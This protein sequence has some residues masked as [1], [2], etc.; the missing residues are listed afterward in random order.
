MER[1]GQ[2]VFLAEA[3]ACDGSKVDMFRKQEEASEAGA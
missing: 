3:K 1:S 2:R